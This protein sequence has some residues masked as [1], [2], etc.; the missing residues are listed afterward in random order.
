[1]VHT[2]QSRPDSG[3]GLK[4]KVVERLQVVPCK[5]STYEKPW[6]GRTRRPARIAVILRGLPG[7]GKS[8]TG[9]TIR[10]IEVANGGEAPRVMSIDDYFLV[11]KNVKKKDEETG[12]MVKVTPH[13]QPRTNPDP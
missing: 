7:S 3:L 9:R 4:G 5:L 13:P 12:L 8:R 10:D 6:P 11:E 2:R 1:M